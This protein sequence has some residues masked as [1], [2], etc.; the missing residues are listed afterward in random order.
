MLGWLWLKSFERAEVRNLNRSTV[1]ASDY[2]LRVQDIPADSTEAELAAHFAQVTGET[3]AAVHLV[4]SNAREIGLYFKRGRLMRRRFNCVQRIRYERTAERTS[5]KEHKGAQVR[6]V[7]RLLQERDELTTLIHMRDEEREQIVASKPRA[8]EAFVTFETEEAVLKAVGEYQHSW[9]RLVCCCYPDRLLFKG[10]RLRVSQS[11]EPSTIIWENLDVPSRSIFL[12]QCLTTGTAM[13]AILLSVVFR[14]LARDFQNQARKN[15]S[16]PCP[17]GFFDLD[18]DVQYSVIQQ[19]I[20]LAHCYCSGLGYSEQWDEALCRGYIQNRVK[21]SAMSYGAGFMVVFMNAFFTWLMDRAGPFERHHSLDEKE[22]SNMARVFFLKFVNTGCLVLLY[23]QRWLQRLVGIRFEDDALDF[24]VDWYATGGVSLI[25]TM[26]LN[27]FTPHLGTVVAY[28][29]QRMRI[30]AL[31]GGI[32]KDGETNDKHKICAWSTSTSAGCT[33]S[34]CRS[35][36][37]SARCPS[38][39]PTGSTSSCSAT[40]LLRQDGKDEHEDHR[41]GGHI[42]PGDER[43]DDGG[44]PEGVSGSD[45]LDQ[46]RR[47]R[48]DFGD[49]GPE[50]LVA[51]LQGPP[52]CHR[53]ALGGLCGRLPPEALSIGPHRCVVEV[54]PV[55]LLLRWGWDDKDAEGHSEHCGDQL[56]QRQ[57]KGRH[58]GDCYLQH[59]SES[60]I[61]RGLWN[62]SRVCAESQACLLNTGVQH[63]G[64]R[65]VRQLRRLRRR[66]GR[67]N[68]GGWEGLIQSHACS[69]WKKQFL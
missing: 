68:G 50:V 31:E 54:L 64:G 8:I 46:W 21:S 28:V 41:S 27:I 44:E 4:Y 37:S 52:S 49:G 2:T 61:P 30:R 59:T 58:Q 13:L 39:S 51:A 20:N 22:A 65:I 11:P 40:S 33:P 26:V 24:N 56:H 1:T 16:K 36:P 25:I 29:R 3:V 5:G 55:P 34:E 19:D 63:E 69:R 23:N 60:E 42:A 18:A 15:T 62:L 12:R 53:G 48:R 66:R 45:G 7:N 32:T 17:D 6:V 14:F 35:C 10:L 57:A 38:T 47:P 43:M 67:V 9:F